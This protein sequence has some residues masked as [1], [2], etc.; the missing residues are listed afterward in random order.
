MLG[1]NAQQLLSVDMLSAYPRVC[2]H[3]KNF[4]D[5]F[6]PPYAPV[7]KDGWV[8]PGIGG[9]DVSNLS[10]AVAANAAAVAQ[11]KDGQWKASTRRALH[12][13]SSHWVVN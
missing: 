12:D 6:V 13:A 5:L 7:F 1:E 2:R 9:K 4:K 11:L 3:S 8:P 10:A